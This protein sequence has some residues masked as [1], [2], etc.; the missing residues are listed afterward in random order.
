[1]VTIVE[2]RS[3]GRRDG[4]IVRNGEQYRGK[5]GAWAE[6][7]VKLGR[8]VT[9]DQADKLWQAIERYAPARSK[10][11]ALDYTAVAIRHNGVATRD[12]QYTRGSITT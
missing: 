11:T 1:E 8:P 2:G 7:I 5:A 12:G 9:R 3:G 4:A 10:L 6:Y